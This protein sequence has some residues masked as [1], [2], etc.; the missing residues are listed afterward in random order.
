M[1]TFW[2]CSLS[3]THILPLLEFIS[4]LVQVIP[5]S[6]TSL[7]DELL[8]DFDDS[9]A[10]DTLLKSEQASAAGAASE[11]ADTPADVPEVIS[12][13]ESYLQN[14]FYRSYSESVKKVLES[15]DKSAIID[16]E[17]NTPIESS[18]LYDSVAEANE[19]LEKIDEYFSQ[20]YQYVVMQYSKRVK[21]IVNLVPEPQDLVKVVMFL[22]HHT[23]VE[24]AK[25]VATDQNAIE[26][27]LGPAQLMTLTVALTGAHEHAL[28]Y[29]EME[30]VLS[31]C[32]LGLRLIQA[33]QLLLQY[34]QLYMEQ[35]GP[36][37]SALI[38]SE[39]AANLVAFTGGMV[40]LSRIP[41]CNLMVVGKKR[42]VLGG[43]S[44]SA[45]LQH[46]GVIAL[47]PL[48]KD[49]PKDCQKKMA[50][51]LA[52][53]IM[54]ATR[55]DCA[56]GSRDGSSGQKFREFCENKL[57]SF[58]KPHQA[59]MHKPL[60]IPGQQKAR[61]RGGKRYR[62]AKE[63]YGLTDVH[64]E[65]K[66]IKFGGTNDEYGDVA[67]GRSMGTLGQNDN[68][69]MRLVN[70][71]KKAKVP[72]GKIWPGKVQK[73]SAP[74]SVGKPGGYFSDATKFTKTS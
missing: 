43:F 61:K 14:P 28:G 32:A 60:P 70:R 9:D 74:P 4:V 15:A 57:I 13:I 12:R 20:A 52:G 64:R 16:S 65:R 39:I 51:I 49:A 22:G 19:F 63:K 10:E 46:V 40:A 54:L 53:K 11:S 48:V 27:V 50:R 17:E 69:R 29:L 7:A 8:D 18:P 26:S 62:K 31:C 72:N 2:F 23:S 67:M 59:K 44:K 21:D 38:G 1:V 3:K 34:I 41:S 36:N 35:L 5:V 73:E 71:D 25:S 37:I 47:S 68:G 56:R 33:R 66:R 42:K 45:Q 58:Q 24:N 55:V 6:M 30:H